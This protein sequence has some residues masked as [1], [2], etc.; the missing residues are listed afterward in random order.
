[1]SKDISKLPRLYVDYPLEDGQDIILDMQQSHYLGNVMRKKSG[2]NIRIFNGKDGEWL[3]EITFVKKKEL[4]LVVKEKLLP[5]PQN[6]QK[7][8]LYFAPI[9]KQRLDFL[10]EKSVELGVTE[11]VPV[12]TANT[13]NRYLKQDRMSSQIIEASEQCERLTVPVLRK[14][15]K[16]SN[17]TKEEGRIM[18]A[19]ERHEGIPHISESKAAAVLIGPEGGFTED[20]VL[21]LKD[22]KNIHPVS[23]GQN[24]LRAETAALY[25]LAYM[26]S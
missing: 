12:I 8:V 17:I 25:A 21:W 14:E 4:S 19:I 1:M 24:V 2:D 18:V 3:S 10:I 23:L 7:K 15:I 11:L 20:E 26:L 13:E 9:K 16:L 6:T 5:Q 22:Q